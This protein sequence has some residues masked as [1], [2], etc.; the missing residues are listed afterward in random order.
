M[1]KHQSKVHYVIRVR[2]NKNERWTEWAET[3]SLDIAHKHLETINNLGWEGAI[4]DRRS[5]NEQRK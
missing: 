4:I 3:K 5:L 1:F 2:R